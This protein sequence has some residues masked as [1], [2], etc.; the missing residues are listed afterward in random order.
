M[1]G[2]GH[3]QA[4]LPFVVGVPRDAAE[5][6][7]AARKALALTPDLRG[8]RARRRGCFEGR[9]PAKRRPGAIAA[10]PPDVAR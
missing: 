7:G 9:L 2:A 5:R 3:S 4:G 6:A 10:W 1:L 8:A